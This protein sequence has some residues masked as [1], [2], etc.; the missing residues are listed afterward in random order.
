M[1]PAAVGQKQ[2]LAVPARCGGG[3][4]PK[5]R[6]R[7]ERQVSQE[8]LFHRA[9][10]VHLPFGLTSALDLRDGSATCERPEADHQCRGPV[11]IAPIGVSFSK[12]VLMSVSA[13]V[14]CNC[15]ER[16]LVTSL[17]KAEWNV[18]VDA[19]GSRNSRTVDLETELEFDRWN[20]SACSHE[21]GVYARAS[22]GNIALVGTLRKVLG[23]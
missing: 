7:S 8:G 15:L 9:A 20:A 2:P 4:L 22:I 17:P 3:R 18:Y 11:L 10:R 1:R 6:P 23:A 14:Y 19:D 16:G 13:C 12:E 5:R 21:L